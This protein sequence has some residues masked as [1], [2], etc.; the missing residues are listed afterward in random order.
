MHRR[1]M[2]FFHVVVSSIMIVTTAKATEVTSRCTDADSF[3]R[4]VEGLSQAEQFEKIIRMAGKKS[5]LSADSRFYVGQAYLALASSE[6]NTPEQEEGYCRKALEYGA[7]QAYMGLYFI[8]APRD[9]AKALGYLRQY[10]DT[11]PA[12]PVPYVILGET[13]LNNGNYEYADRYLR[14]SRKV[15]RTSS[16]RVDWMLFQA[17]YLIGNYAYASQM[18]DSAMSNG[19]FDQE[20]GALSADPRFRGIEKRPEFRKHR[21]WITA[22][23]IR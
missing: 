4:Q 10:I 16:A 18:L 6:S 22:S 13:E 2:M 15:A 11:K 23:N 21:K 1:K 17:N 9:E 19:R 7:T 8:N 20:L 3:C 5:S 12:D 14:E